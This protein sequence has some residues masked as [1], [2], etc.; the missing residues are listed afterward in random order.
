MCVHCCG[1]ACG[2]MLS[3]EGEAG[4]RETATSLASK[5]QHILALWAV[6]GLNLFILPL[7][8]PDTNSEQLRHKDGDVSPDFANFPS[9]KQS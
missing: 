3:M 6:S 4:G 5:L 1:V 2:L 7:L 9:T 8:H